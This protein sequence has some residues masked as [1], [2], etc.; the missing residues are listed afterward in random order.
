MKVLVPVVHAVGDT[1]FEMG[2]PFESQE[3]HERGLHEHWL[4]WRKFILGQVMSQM[5]K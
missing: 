4:G 2:Y 3:T 5:K 1:V